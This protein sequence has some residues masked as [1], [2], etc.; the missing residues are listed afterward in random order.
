MF[1]RSYAVLAIVSIFP[2]AP[3]VFAADFPFSDVPASD[4]IRS[5][6]QKLYER[7]VIDV[8]E[9]GKF[10]PEALMDRDEFTAIAIGVGCRKCLTPSVSDVLKYRTAP[11]ADFPMKNP[12]FYC[13]SYAKDR[14]IVQ[15]YSAAG[16]SGYACED[17]RAWEDVP[18][19]P[20]NRIS[21]I[22]AAAVLLRQAGL[23]NDVRNAAPVSRSVE[24]S[25]VSDYWYAY[26][27]KGV[28]IGIL[29]TESGSLRPN[30]RLSKREF[31]R[32]ASVIFSVNL[33]EVKGMEGDGL[34]ASGTSVGSAS[35]PS[36]SSTGSSRATRSGDGSGTNSGT[37]S[38]SS[39]S[40]S[41]GAAPAVAASVHRSGTS[42]NAS[43]PASYVPPGASYDFSA[44]PVIPGASYHWQFFPVSGTANF[45]A[46]GACVSNVALDAGVW[47]ARVT[48][49]DSSGRTAVSSV[50]V[51][52]GGVSGSG[53]L[54][55]SAE[56]SPLEAVVGSRVAFSGS[57]SGGTGPYAY[58][59]DFS[60]GTVSTERNLRHAYE[61]PGSRL[62]TLTVTDSNGNRGIATLTVSVLPNVDADGDGVLGADDRCPYVRGPASNAGCPNVETYSGQSSGGSLF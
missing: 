45:V 11:F 17:G 53:I 25:D 14:G 5:D 34:S 39:I 21:R 36:S 46:D 4:P 30:E 49:S 37:G 62:A 27:K 1:L 35:T 51:P 56:A 61:N 6:L 2:A 41:S 57:V 13:V 59:W 19:C 8:P 55:V 7:G 58:R 38:F 29:R 40:A 24:I 28:E 43:A 32:M 52:F 48:V 3:G 44:S 12:Y 10:H 15:G 22:E 16:T 54:S 26:A 20:D 50:T 18:F 47:I 42:C 60:D 33:C 9:D 23:W 31:V